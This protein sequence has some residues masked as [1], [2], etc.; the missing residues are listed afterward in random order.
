M[1]VLVDFE[2]SREFFGDE[3]R[4]SEDIL[5]NGAA[6][7]IASLPSSDRDSA[8]SVGS[9]SM[10][11]GPLDTLASLS[12]S[13]LFDQ[14]SSIN[15]T[16]GGGCVSAVCGYFAV[17]LLLKS[18]RISSRTHPDDVSLSDVD[19]KLASLA[20]K[21]LALAE[22]DSDSFSKY[23]IALKMAKT[24]PAEIAARQHAI[25]EAVVGAAVAALN[26]LDAGNQ[27]LDVAHHVQGR[28]LVSIIADEKSAVELIS[29]MNSTA[30]WNAD[31]N[32]ASKPDEVEMAKRLMDAK[33]KHAALIA[34]CRGG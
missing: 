29:V 21:L 17:S 18:V 9:C 25:D 7:C 34:A 15:P 13:G 27:I 8:S 32:L 5:S 23:M 2:A 26:I 28:V 16:P 3:W 1:D 31:A 14:A 11:A 10:N 22:A 19:R 20:P 6:K 30:E 4:M 24:T 12:V 33:A